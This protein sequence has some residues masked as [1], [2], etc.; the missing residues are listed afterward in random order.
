MKQSMS[1]A[2]LACLLAVLSCTQ[3]PQKVLESAS[4]SS[5]DSNG[6]V[7][8]HSLD[9]GLS[10]P[11]G[12]LTNRDLFNEIYFQGDTVCFSFLLAKE[13]R[14]ET[15]KV[16]FINPSDGSAFPAERVDITDNR[17]HGF[18][19]AGTL[20]EQFC[21]VSPA[22]AAKITAGSEIPCSARVKVSDGNI[23][24]TETV[25]CSFRILLNPSLSR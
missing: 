2:A 18:S 9:F 20:L 13:P 1:T 23:I 5:L 3:Q 4:G 14:S 16:E 11:A 17:I 24:I 19:L 25:D 22:L 12:P 8:R 6:A 10:A 21:G 7:S 15:V